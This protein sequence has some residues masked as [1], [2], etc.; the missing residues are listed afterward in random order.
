MLINSI[1]III[2]IVSS[3]TQKDIATV[4][5]RFSLNILIS[6]LINSFNLFNLTIFSKGLGILNGL[7]LVTCL[8]QNFKIFI[9]IV[10]LFIIFFTSFY[11]YKVYIEK[12]EIKVECL[13]NN[14]EDRQYWG[15]MNT[16]NSDFRQETSKL[17]EYQ[18]R[19]D[20]S[21]INK[22]SG[23]QSLMYD[24][25][26]KEDRELYLKYKDKITNYIY[27]KNKN[28]EQYRILEYTIIILIIL[29]GASF[30]ISTNDLVSLF[31]C[32]E[33]QSYGLYI[34]CALY[35][36]SELS[37]TAG[38]TY[39]LLGALA[40]CFVLLG[41][42][43]MYSNSGNFYLDSFEIISNILGD[44]INNTYLIWYNTNYIS[45]SL[46]ILTVGLLFKISA[47]PFHV[48]SPDVYDNV[49]TIVTTFLALIPK[50]SILILILELVHYTSNISLF[51]Q[52]NWKNSLLLSSFLSLI[53]GTILGL[54]QTRIKRLLAYSTISHLGFILLGLSVNS[55]ESNQSFLFYLIQYTLSNLNIF[56][57]LL[58]I[59]YSLVLYITNNPEFNELKDKKYSNIQLIDQL[60]G[61]HTLNPIMSLSLSVTLFS[62]MGIPP[63]I[64]FFGKQM[65]LSSA[66]D[67]G[68]V[69]LVLI[70]IITSVIGGVYYLNII[71]KIY[72][73]ESEYKE[74]YKNEYKNKNKSTVLYILFGIKTNFKLKKVIYFKDNIFIFGHLSLTISI[75]TNLI[76]FFIFIPQE[77]LNLCNIM[78]LVVYT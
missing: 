47:A 27:N 70:A 9:F 64:G 20:L 35:K 68:Y 2:I 29:T 45:Y 40:S 78:T 33:L 42:S 73:E 6:C 23:S 60:K 49:P 76:I 50:I 19:Q 43:F 67:K 77:F 59:G 55:I 46:L 72:F 39:F 54:S 51:E 13:I 25:H 14:P 36:K 3:I 38:L 66:L 48:W 21:V 8:T 34:L 37:T 24:N 75:L 1:I 53:I 15:L 61:Y 65:I 22:I 10:S 16:I 7:F 12:E 69:F 63:L 74:K 32:L 57:I 4:V 18:M 28:L 11:P 58:S 44:N 26:I 71:R 17:R 31:I 52:F 56:I 41:C 5:S 30:L 62:F